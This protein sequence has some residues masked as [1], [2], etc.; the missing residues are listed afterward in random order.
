MQTCHLNIQE[1]NIRMILLINIRQ[2]AG[3]LCNTDINVFFHFM[4]MSGDH[5]TQG[6]QGNPLI[7]SKH[8]FIHIV[9][10]LCLH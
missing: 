7:I 6:I 9:T 4:K 5:D 2:L 3:I 10:P 8:N 1:K